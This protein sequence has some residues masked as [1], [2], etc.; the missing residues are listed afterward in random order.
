VF[1]KDVPV[2]DFEGRPPG[3]PDREN[4]SPFAGGLAASLGDTLLSAVALFFSVLYVASMTGF[5]V[6]PAEEISHRPGNT[7]L[8]IIGI[9]GG[10]GILILLLRAYGAA[11]RSFVFDSTLQFVEPSE[12]VPSIAVIVMYGNIILIT[13][14]LFVLTVAALGVM[15]DRLR[16]S[17]RNATPGELWVLI[18]GIYLLMTVIFLW[19]NRVPQFPWYAPFLVFGGA[20]G[21]LLWP[22]SAEG[23]TRNIFGRLSSISVLL[24]LSF[25]LSVSVLDEKI[26][27]KEED[28]IRLYAHQLTR[29]VD[30]WLSFVLT[31]SFRS[32][33]EEYHALTDGA[34]LEAGVNLA[35][36]LWAKTLMGKEGYN[37]TLVLYD[38]SG[39]EID[40]FTVGL[41][42]YE[43]SELLK[44][45]FDV[46]EEGLNVVERRVQEGLIKY[47][48]LWGTIR[49]EQNRL[50]RPSLLTLPVRGPR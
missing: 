24:V 13:I 2:I 33:V 43:Q 42:T 37:S 5:P 7:I 8:T 4:A 14:A 47:Y 35:F 50:L 12:V 3:V 11:L 10:S 16:S 22:G 48:G 1:A 31:E 18:F 29:P 40:R 41:T 26:H 25:I 27:E 45:L 15:S 20:A 30:A 28:R 34:E 6:K 36:P 38:K 19:L 32:A 9:A 46:G 21:L 23:V 49:D 39:Y 17:F 44:R